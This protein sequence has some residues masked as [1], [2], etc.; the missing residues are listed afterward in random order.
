MDEL[1]MG[2][3]RQLDA[4]GMEDDGALP[5][6]PCDEMMSQDRYPELDPDDTDAWL[7]GLPDDIR[8]EVLAPHPSAWAASGEA[9]PAGFAGGGFFD[10]ALPGSWLGQA[11]AS[12]TS[13]GHAELD[14]SELYGVLRGWQRQVSYAQAGLAAAAIALAGRRAA[15]SSQAAE[16]LADELAIEL[17]LTARSTGRLLDVVSGLRRLV[18]VHEAMLNGAIDWARACVFVDE[19]AVVADDAI[20]QALAGRLVDQAA[21]WTTGQLRAAPSPAHETRRL[22][23]RAASVGRG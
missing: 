3:S 10:T 6:W 21:D 4:S 2:E 19:L 11:L 15:G 18:D 23:V 22:P 14:E 12:V 9:D 17:M 8:A 1:D 13:G 5:G 20:A 7:A 16:H